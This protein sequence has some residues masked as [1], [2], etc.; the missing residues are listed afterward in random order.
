MHMGNVLI[1]FKCVNCLNLH[2][3]A[4]TNTDAYIVK[5]KFSSFYIEI[6]SCHTLWLSLCSV[7]LRILTVQ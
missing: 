7:V 3:F 6:F 1:I 5:I 2:C 4:L